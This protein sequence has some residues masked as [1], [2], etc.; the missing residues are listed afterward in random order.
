MKKVCLAV[1][2]FI[3][4]AL[5]S[6]CQRKEAKAPGPVQKKLSVIT[7]LF[8]LY[9][10]ARTVGGDKVDVTLLLPPGVEAHHFDPRPDDIIK[11][12]KA[13]VFIYTNEQMEPWAGKLLKGVASSTLLVVDTSK[14]VKLLEA[15][16]GGEHG[17]EHHHHHDGIDPHIW[18]DFA[19]ARIMV[20]NIAT[21][22]A[23]KDPANKD[24]YATK[25]AVY[26]A[27][28]QKLDD[29]FKAGL[30]AC[31]TREFLHGGHN[32]FGYLTRRY[33]LTYRPALQSM[34]ADSEPTPAEL[35]GLVKHMR[36]QGLKYIYSEELLSPRTAET[37]AKE[38][39]AGILLFHGAHNIS[40]EDLDK[41]VTFIS[42]MKKNLENLRIGLQCH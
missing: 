24:Y 20:D 39:G 40:R 2:L 29:E 10:F 4:L 5:L 13:D 23:E 37:I 33:G 19:N 34:S 32:A 31:G 18:L 26:K 27:E 35:A 8:P 21:G 38:T 17:G 25:A 6:A 3:G 15:A 11:I 12:T 7:S 14:G 42:L 22:M 1:M 28:L 41:G 36:K 30:T 16:L 9:D